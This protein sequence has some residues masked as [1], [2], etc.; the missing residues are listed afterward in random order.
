MITIAR[1]QTAD[2]EINQLQSNIAQALGPLLSNDQAQG[3]LLKSIA[4]ASGSNSVNHGLGKALT[5]WSVAR[6]RA[7]AL[8]WDAQDANPTP[9]TTLSLVASAAVTLDLYVW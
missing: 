2:R 6:L 1:V 7:Q 4:L 8:V 5:G 9:D 3:H